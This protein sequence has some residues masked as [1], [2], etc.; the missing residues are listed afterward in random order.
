ML[1]PGQINHQLTTSYG[2]MVKEEEVEVEDEQD[3]KPSLEELEVRFR[4]VR[5]KMAPNSRIFIL[6]KEFLNLALSESD[7]SCLQ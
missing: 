2:N 3:V 6:R 5:G 1:E 4:E 7:N